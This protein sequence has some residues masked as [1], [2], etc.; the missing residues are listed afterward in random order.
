MLANIAWFVAGLGG[1][2]QY[3]GDIDRRAADPNAVMR[4]DRDDWL[5]TSDHLG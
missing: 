4:V 3:R 5:G 1:I 2:Q